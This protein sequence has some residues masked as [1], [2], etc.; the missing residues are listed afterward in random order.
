MNEDQQA[1]QIS[2]RIER[3]P[4]SRWHFRALG[5]CGT[6]DFMDAFDSLTL[7]FVMPVLSVAWQIPRSDVGWLISAGFIGQAIGAVVLG[8]TAEKYGRV[9]LLT[10]TLAVI[11]IFSG[12]CALAQDFSQLFWLR[13]IQGLAI[14]AEVPIAA[15]YMNE[16]VM[17]RHR[18]TFTISI[19]AMFGFGVLVSSFIAA[20]MV[21]TFGWASMFW[22]GAAPALVALPLRWLL[23][24]SP[25]WLAGVG[26]VKEAEAAMR[27]IEDIVS[28]NGKYPLPAPDA[29]PPA[30]VKPNTS[31]VQLFEGIYARRTLASWILMFT[32]AYVSYSLL[33]WIPSI[34]STVYRMPVNDALNYT[35]YI[36]CIGF[37]G[38]LTALVIIDRMPRRAYF[39][40]SF[41][42]AAAALFLLGLAG[43][44]ASVMTLVVLLSIARYFTAFSQTGIFVYV[45]E[46]YP[47]RMRAI[48]VGTASAWQR[49]ATVIGPVVIGYILEIGSISW[50]YF[51]FVAVGVAALCNVVFLMIEGRGRVLEELS[52]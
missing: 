9:T 36:G 7:A 12:L 11:A 40:M 51:M 35:F 42:G 37:C 44:G 1:A 23:P 19:Q 46:V 27:Q 43:V 10:W 2:A 32:N 21:P 25:R 28:Q 39:F 22:L 45:P 49:I 6:A 3:L 5:I 17:A 15:A 16:I 41:A 52:P 29:N 13:T 4:V 47:T 26:R 14:G 48:G 24:E 8:W 34:L 18:G 30:L 33:T 20:K 38:T 31:F 50:V